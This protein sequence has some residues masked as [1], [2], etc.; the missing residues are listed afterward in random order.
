[1][2]TS[3]DQ[4]FQ[5]YEQYNREADFYAND[6]RPSD[7]FTFG[8][9]WRDRQAD[10][11]QQKAADALNLYGAK[12]Q[13]EFEERLDNTKYQRAVKDLAAAGFSPLALLSNSPTSAPSGVAAS[14]SSGR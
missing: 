3:Q 6:I 14:Y 13:Q 12:Q 5:S 7:L 1:M 9:T 11:A 10:R 4:A 2:I 8:S